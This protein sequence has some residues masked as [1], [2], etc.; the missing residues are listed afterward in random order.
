MA[1]YFPVTPDELSE[2]T[3]PRPGVLALCDA[4]RAQEPD[5]IDR[6]EIYN[7]RRIGGPKSPWS[8]HAVGRGVD[9]F[10]EGKVASSWVIGRGDRYP[11]T[12]LLVCIAGALV[13]SATAL[14][15]QEVILGRSRWTLG[16]WKPYSRSPHWSHVH[17]SCTPEFADSPAPHE[18]A[19]ALC[20]LAYESSRRFSRS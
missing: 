15:V 7:R 4:I 12:E 1:R 16:G 11:G 9:I 20:R 3:G 8:T 13:G 18:L 10:P 6:V 17:F 14:G 5:G 19:V 2:H